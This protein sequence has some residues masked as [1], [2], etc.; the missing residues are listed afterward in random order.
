MRVRL[1]SLSLCQ[2]CKTQEVQSVAGS[3]ANSMAGASGPH[4]SEVQRATAEYRLLVLYNKTLVVALP[5]QLAR[6]TLGT[7]TQA[8]NNV[9][10]QV[11]QLVAFTGLD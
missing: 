11:T 9:M 1:Q 6:N 2:P 4:R 3:T 5:L 7:A 8:R 10:H